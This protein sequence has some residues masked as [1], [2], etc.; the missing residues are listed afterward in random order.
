MHAHDCSLTEI[1]Q[2]RSTTSHKYWKF[3]PLLERLLSQLN[4]STEL[5]ACSPKPWSFI[6]KKWLFYQNTLRLRII[7]KKMQCRRSA[8]IYVNLPHHLCFHQPPR[9][10]LHRAAVWGPGAASAERCTHPAK[11]D[12]CFPPPIAERQWL[13]NVGIDQAWILCLSLI[14]IC[15]VSEFWK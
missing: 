11:R 9:N 3:Y 13:P 8:A 14:R 7:L 6:R 15:I 5:W 2:S 10:S 1:I 12:C 4:A